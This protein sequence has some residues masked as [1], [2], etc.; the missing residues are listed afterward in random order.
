VRGDDDLW[1]INIEDPSFGGGE[2][3]RGILMVVNRG[4]DR[5]FGFE[6]LRI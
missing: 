4:V 5:V 6:I 2:V 3:D 1:D